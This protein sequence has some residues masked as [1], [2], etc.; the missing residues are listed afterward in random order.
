[1]TGRIDLI[2]ACFVFMK[3]TIGL[4][5]TADHRYRE[6][7]LPETALTNHEVCRM[8]QMRLGRQ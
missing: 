1:M 2:E 8:H 7:S 6:E 3:Q 5:E 4:D